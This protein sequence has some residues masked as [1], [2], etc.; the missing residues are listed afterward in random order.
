MAN[1]RTKARI[2]RSKKQAK[3]DM[4]ALELGIKKARPTLKIK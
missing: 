3:R 2:K 1:K 4:L